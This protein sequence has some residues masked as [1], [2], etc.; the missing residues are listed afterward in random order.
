[1]E[2][3]FRNCIY[4]GKNLFREKSFLFWSLIYPIV[5]SLFFYTAFNGIINLELEKIEVGIESDN[6]IIFILEDIELLNL[7]KINV[8][9]SSDKL[10]NE[11]IDGFID[12]DFNLLVA[13][14][15]IDQSIIKQIL[16]EVKQSIKL[17]RGIES[18]DLSRDYVVDRN[19]NANGIIIIFYS[20]IGMVSTYGVFA[21][22]ECISLIQ[23]NLT[24]V[25]KRINLSPIKK[26][27]FLLG[28]IIVALTLNLLSNGLLLFFINYILK[29][30]LI[31]ELKYSLIFILLGNIFGVALGMFIGVSNKK[32]NN[33]K[34]LL[35]IVITL[36]LSFLA[37]MMA[38]D[39]KVLIDQNIP[40]I[41]RFNP[42]SI[43][44]NNLY[45]INLL[46][47]TEGAVEGIIAL[48][49]YSFVLILISYVL[50]RRK[51]Y[52]SL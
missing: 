16:D 4:Q 23:A 30:D 37:G 7:H 47:I 43:M 8:E 14:S 51:T 11:E 39:I 18:L 2:K 36:F 22:I 41:G 17:N 34:V 48:S 26:M 9:E 13:K 10:E 32:S 5:L 1:M 33:T 29:I 38:P 40:I 20:L 27:E 49:I 42:I 46:G 24:D 35:S 12:K 44:T 25:A 15:G 50:L 19:Q 31:T 3:L 6:P 52:D 21:S 45:R 28:G